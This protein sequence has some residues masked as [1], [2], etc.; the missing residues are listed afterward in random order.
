MFDYLSQPV[1]R[2]RGDHAQSIV[3][4]QLVADV[5]GGI[6]LTDRA[7]IGIHLPF[8]LVNAGS[9]AGDEFS[10]ATVGD[11]ALQPKVQVLTHE[12]SPIG[13]AARLDVTLPT[14]EGTAF[15]G[16]PGVGVRPKLIADA[17]AGPAT[18]AVNV[19]SVFT[20]SGAIE[21]IEVGNRFTYGFSAEYQIVEGLLGVAGEL[22]GHTPY[23]QFFSDIN[24]A[25]LEGL[26]GAK[27]RTDAG[28]VVS[29]AAGGGIAPGIGA[30]EFRA[31][32]GVSYPTEVADTDGDGLVDGNDECPNE[33]EDIDGFED[34]NGCP[35]PDNDGDGLADA[36]D[37]CSN[38]NEDMD[39]F[40][41]EDGCA[42]LDND[43][44]GVPDE[45]DECADEPEDRNDFQDEDG[46]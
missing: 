13:L 44:D 28:A 32:I 31:I 34:D 35:E 36:E 30:P 18:L 27:L 38:E 12:Q 45:P 39:G 1:V 3:D 26:L 46:C 22:Y 2:G 25:P 16:N 37:E 11:L 19:G 15:V 4:Q 14:G 9:F 43:Q 42:E 5:L 6:G 29:A 8:Y 21:N 33:R 7:Q 40:E 10:G 41:D 20:P 17:E 23:S 24:D